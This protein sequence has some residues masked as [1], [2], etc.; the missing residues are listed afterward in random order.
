MI[1]RWALLAVVVFCTL[2]SSSIAQVNIKARVEISFSLMGNQYYVFK[3]PQHLD[4]GKSA[5]LEIAIG[6]IIGDILPASS[7]SS[8]DA[9][10]SKLSIDVKNKVTDNY[11]FPN[12]KIQN[13]FVISV[14]A[15][16][17]NSN[18]L[19][20]GVF[21]SSSGDT[22]R[23]SGGQLQIV[24]G[25]YETIQYAA[26][27]IMPD[28]EETTIYFHVYGCGL[29]DDFPCIITR[30]SV[31]LGGTNYYYTKDEDDKLTIYKTS[32]PQLED[33]GLS[34]TTWVVEPYSDNKATYGKRLG[35]YWETEKP[36]YETTETLPAGLIRLVGRYWTADST[37]KVRLIALADE[38]RD[39]AVIEVKKPSKLGDGYY[40]ED[41]KGNRTKI[42]DKTI[43]DV[44]NNAYDPNLDD[45]IIKY[46]GLYGIPPQVIKGDIQKESTFQPGYR[47][48][49]FVNIVFQMKKSPTSKF[50]DDD[51]RYLKTS[52]S[53]G[54][55]GVPIDHSNVHDCNGQLI[56][57]PIKGINNY[58]IWEILFKYSKT[59]NPNSTSNLYPISLWYD[60]D[61]IKGWN[62]CYKKKLREVNDKQAAIDYA[63]AWLRDEYQKG[64]ISECT[65]Q[66]RSV[67]SY[68]LMQMM[69]TT[70]VIERGYPFESI[71]G[72]Q[73]HLPEY[74]NLTDTSLT[75]GTQYLNSKI[76]EELKEEGD[77]IGKP[78]NWTLGYER[79]IIVGLNM[80]NGKSL[81]TKRYNWFYGFK[82]L[83]FSE[84]YKPQN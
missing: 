25:T 80:Y 65:A 19:Y 12:T 46:A 35:V 54:D 40:S 69:Y 68:G 48:E 26:V 23:P 9:R 51:F 6:E 45:I 52:T 81:L 56:S 13:E 32:D 22:I 66:T 60:G 24:V 3:H 18:S 67:A 28:S 77:G 72:T 43:K 16:K 82:I 17:P 78:D 63:N 27:G 79:T 38:K 58:T 7:S 75:Y 1:R 39:T 21:I 15:D 2:I 59:L 61:A 84:Q 10:L 50:L 8:K 76:N 20:R 33:G 64:I 71:G 14:V 47:Y 44:L 70:A 34:T 5:D 49:P 11:H 53:D 29:D 41:S 36:I 73:T 62:S 83:S 4:Y 74:L 30:K 37:Y 55:P 57:Y 31:L 42:A